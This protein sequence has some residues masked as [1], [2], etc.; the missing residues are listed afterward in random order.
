[1]TSTRTPAP[2]P[3]ARDLVPTRTFFELSSADVAYAGG[4]GANLGQLTRVGLPVPPGFV[5]S[6]P[7]F[8]QATK[9]GGRG[10]AEGELPSWLAEA[11][12]AGLE[13]LVGANSAVAVRSS[14]GTF[15]NVRG[16]DRVLDAVRRC[17]PGDADGAVVVQR[18]VLSTRAGVMVTVD[19]VSGNRDHL[20]IEGSFGLGAVPGSSQVSPDRFVVDKDRMTIVTRDIRTQG[21][22]VEP[23]EDSGT[24]TREMIPDEGQRPALDDDELLRLAELGI[25]IEREFGSAQAIDWAFD[26]DDAIWML[27]SRPVAVRP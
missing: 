15:L 6:A 23:D 27:G 13:K 25:A 17:W 22:V 4:Q 18:Q 5:V 12:V 19:L 21:L 16:C 7:A 26:E 1:M 9:E 3:A 11:I 8:R 20:G 14:S 24:R 10:T 2:P